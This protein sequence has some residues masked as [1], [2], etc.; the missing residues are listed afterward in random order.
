MR[1]ERWWGLGL[2]AVLALPA[3]AQEQGVSQAVEGE[4]G[5]S[6]LGGAGLARVRSAFMAWFSCSTCISV[7]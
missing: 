4:V 6:H 2:V 7:A 3:A 1:L 5:R